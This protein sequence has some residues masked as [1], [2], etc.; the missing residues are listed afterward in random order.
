MLK[1]R[2]LVV[3]LAIPELFYGCSQHLNKPVQQSTQ[4]ITEDDAIYKGK[5]TMLSEIY[6][7]PKPAGI[8]E[9]DVRDVVLQ[10][11]PMGTKKTSVLQTL[12]KEKINTI[13]EKD[14]S[15]IIVR[16]ILDKSVLI[17]SPAVAIVF[18]FDTENTLIQIEASY[19][20]KQ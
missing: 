13:I 4:I 7:R 8:E 12:E 2:N 17:G 18:S 15:T 10:H 11:I 9:I 6:S 16:D 5:H 3:L 20:I 1:F 19:F 14:C